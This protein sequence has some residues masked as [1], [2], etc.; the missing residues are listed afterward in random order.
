MKQWFGHESDAANPHQVHDYVIYK[1]HEDTLMARYRDNEARIKAEIERLL[2]FLN[3]AGQWSI[4]I[5]QNGDDFWV[6]DMALAENSALSHCIPE[7]LLRHRE[8]N[9]LPVLS[10]AETK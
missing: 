4:D 9:W 1:A 2:P 7:G 5:M 3:L 8:E 10:G 6:I